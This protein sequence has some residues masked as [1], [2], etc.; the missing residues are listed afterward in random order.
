MAAKII[1]I[2]ASK[3]GF[4]AEEATAYYAEHKS[5]AGS[6]TSMTTVQRAESAISK[7]Q[8]KIDELKA[9]LPEKKGKLLEKANES[10]KK[11]NEKLEEQMKKLEVKKAK[12]A[13]KAAPKPPK[14]EKAPKKEPAAD[15]S[16]KRIK[17]VSPTIT[18]QLTKTFEE[19]DLT[20]A[21]EDGQAFAKYIN[22][23]EQE[24]FDATSLADHMRDFATKKKMAAPKVEEP[25]ADPDEE[26]VE[27]A[28]K[29]IKYVV[30]EVSK[31]V[32]IADEENGDQFAGFVGMGKFKDMKMPA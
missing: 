7:T 21:K 11:L 27:V 20:Y 4:D 2:L 24:D 13:K 29:G 31:R 28:F 9:K 26:M 5:E 6:T 15:G 18:K 22:E 8:T 14:K 3:Y 17:R 25:E 1:S 16:E 32:Y 30:G 23:L 19:K 12:E 10:L